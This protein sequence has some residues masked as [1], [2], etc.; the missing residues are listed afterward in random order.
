MFSVLSSVFIQR[1]MLRLLI[2]ILL[3]GSIY[4]CQAQRQFIYRG[5]QFIMSKSDTMLTTDPVTGI[6]EKMTI[7]PRPVMMNGEQIYTTDALKTFP[8]LKSAGDKKISVYLFD[9]LKRQLSALDDGNY[10]VSIDNV[11]LDKKGRLVYYELKGIKKLVSKT[12]F[13]TPASK[14]IYKDS[15]HVT[16]M[17]DNKIAGQQKITDS[18]ANAAMPIAMTLL[19]LEPRAGNEVYDNQA[20]PAKVYSRIDNTDTEEGIDAGIK[21]EINKEVSNLL[22]QLP[23]MRPAIHDKVNVNCTGT[24]FSSWNYFTVRGHIASFT[25]FYDGL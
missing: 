5:N 4:T 12:L 2:L 1:I 20:A 11:V 6:S 16:S 8:F 22:E 18:G 25:P 15:I 21:S 14:N 7:A 23:R 17:L 3:A 24:V 9:K 13:V 10:I 19:P